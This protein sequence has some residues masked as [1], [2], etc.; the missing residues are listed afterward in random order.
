VVAFAC[1]IPISKKRNQANVLA[2]IDQGS[3]AFAARQRGDGI[4]AA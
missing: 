1:G 4:D 2:L 3:R